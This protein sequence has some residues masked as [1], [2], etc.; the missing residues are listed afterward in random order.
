MVP[1]FDWFYG[2]SGILVVARA[3]SGES[4]SSERGFNQESWDPEPL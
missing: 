2:K 4:V 1:N 3:V